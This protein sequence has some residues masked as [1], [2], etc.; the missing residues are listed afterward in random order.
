MA[1]TKQISIRLDE[2][3]LAEVDAEALRLGVSRNLVISR[4]VEKL[5][6]LYSVDRESGVIS[7]VPENGESRKKIADDSAGVVGENPACAPM[8]KRGLGESE[9]ELSDEGMEILY[10]RTGDTSN[11]GAI[12]VPV[13]KKIAGKKHV[14]GVAVRLEKTSGGS[15]TLMAAK[16][17]EATMNTL[18]D[19]CAG[20]INNVLITPTM[21]ADGNF[22][23]QEIDLCWRKEYNPDTGQTGACGLEKGHKGKCG[24]WEVVE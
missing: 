6:P 5:P 20:K 1:I 23:A 4:R 3:V 22:E 7:I 10:G 9:A 16:V 19:I 8:G 18:R 12:V 24:A 2:T 21:G 17:P 13:Q 15:T 11:F 14:P